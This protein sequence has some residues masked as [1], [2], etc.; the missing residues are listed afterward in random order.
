MQ[1][2]DKSGAEYTNHVNTD[3]AA[4]VVEIGGILDR[5][6]NTESYEIMVEDKTKTRPFKTILELW[7]KT[8]E[9]GSG[10]F[11]TRLSSLC[12]SNYARFELTNR[13]RYCEVAREF[14]IL[15]ISEVIKE[16]QKAM[17]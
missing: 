1:I 14:F 3:M 6:D 15:I 13:M 8:R 10:D 5:G 4:L 7:F 9:C 2:A 17:Q 11:R 16:L 12:S